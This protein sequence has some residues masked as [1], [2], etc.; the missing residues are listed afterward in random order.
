MQQSGRPLGTWIRHGSRPNKKKHTVVCSGLA[1]GATR[2]SP[3]RRAASDTSM[4]SW[5][6]RSATYPIAARARWPLTFLW[7]ERP[8]GGTLQCTLVCKDGKVGEHADPGTA[9]TCTICRSSMRGASSCQGPASNWHE[10]HL[11]SIRVLL[12]ACPAAPHVARWSKCSIG[13]LSQRGGDVRWTLVK[14]L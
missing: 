10:A 5:L 1:V 3:L 6:P 7:Y 2:S 4:N 14:V 12:T 11:V 8:W 13:A 9:P